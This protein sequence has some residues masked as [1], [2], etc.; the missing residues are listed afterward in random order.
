LPAALDPVSA[1]ATNKLQGS[2]GTASATWAFWR[3]GKL[4]IRANLQSIITVLAGSAL[5]VMTVHFVSSAWL[6]AFMPVLLV[7]V[8]LYFA[9]SPRP[10]EH[11]SHPRL[12]IKTFT[13]GFAPA[14]GF[15]DG[16]FGPGT[17]SFFMASLVALFGT[18]MI[19]ATARTKLLN[20]MSNIA[21]LVL[22]AIGSKIFW[23]I[24]LCMG[25]SQFIGAQLGVRLAIRNGAR[26]IRPLLVVVCLA[27]AAKLLAGHYGLF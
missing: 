26:V 6:S 17:G 10:S 18:S 24:G 22:F 11:C 2:F 23:T 20:F 19:E 27:M 3:K 7:I 13:F 25:L 15:Y 16:F 21:A 12:P 9:L 14:I 1:L 4:D 5:G 8:A